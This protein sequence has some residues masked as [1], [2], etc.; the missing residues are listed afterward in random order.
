MIA[1]KYQFQGALFVRHTVRAPAPFALPTRDLSV[2]GSEGERERGRLR[3]ERRWSGRK[4]QQKREREGGGTER[5][6]LKRIS[7]HRNLVV[8]SQILVT[9]DVGVDRSERFILN[10]LAKMHDAIIMPERKR[11]NAR[12]RISSG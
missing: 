6:H 1:R 4:R 10:S 11:T 8:T 3:G 2:R 5:N 12:T 9:D 7:K